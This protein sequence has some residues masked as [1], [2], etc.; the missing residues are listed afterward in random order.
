MSGARARNE[1]ANGFPQELDDGVEPWN[2]S[3]NAALGADI[4]AAGDTAR[5]LPGTVMPHRP[6]R[7]TTRA[8]RRDP[9]L[10]PLRQVVRERQ[11]ILVQPIVTP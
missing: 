8:A 9:D 10:L 11:G 3:E 1:R 5:R 6:H 2:G 4:P 7:M